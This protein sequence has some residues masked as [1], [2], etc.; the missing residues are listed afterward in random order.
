M[1]IPILILT[2]YSTIPVRFNNDT[3]H[4][5]HSYE[6]RTVPMYHN[7][8]THYSSSRFLHPSIHPSLS[9]M[10]SLFSKLLLLL[11]LLG[12]SNHH[13]VVGVLAVVVV[14]V[15]EQQLQ[16]Q[17]EQQQQNLPEVSELLSQIE[18]LWQRTNQLENQHVLLEE[19]QEQVNSLIQNANGIQ[20]DHFLSRLQLAYQQEI[21]LRSSNTYNIIPMDDLKRR[22]NTQQVMEESE[23]NLQTW[24]LG[25]VEEELERYQK[26]NAYPHTTCPSA[27]EIVQ[28]IQVALTEFSQD[29][30]GS[31]DHAQGGEIV[32]SMTSPTYESTT[33]SSSLLLGNVW[34]RK[35]IPQDWEKWLLPSGWQDWS[36]GL[37]S[38]VYH[39]L[40]GDCVCCVVLCCVLY[41]LFIYRT[42][43]LTRLFV[44]VSVF[45]YIY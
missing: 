9:L 26:N 39:S 13:L 29:G 45:I 35:Y 6:Y 18:E 42:F 30:I 3:Q 43:I 25:I 22:F 24:I 41:Y 5:I 8:T 15:E 4:V 32:H 27:T 1:P 34:W 23:T 37:P 33:D 11:L 21:V 28:Q 40:V 38:F 12:C 14:V 20:L 2:A 7:I 17:L 19:R 44:C 31:I 10:R 16:Q 36:V